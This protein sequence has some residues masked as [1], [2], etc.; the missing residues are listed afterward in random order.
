MINGFMVWFTSYLIPGFTIRDFGTA[1]WA[2][3][4][5]S[6]ISWLI[7]MILIKRYE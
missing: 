6:I 3:I 4:L 5:L 2:A 1:F 7:E